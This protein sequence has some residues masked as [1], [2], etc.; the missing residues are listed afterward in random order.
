MSEVFHRFGGHA[1]RKA[2]RKDVLV[3]PLRLRLS[4]H[5]V[6][7]ETPFF[8]DGREASEATTHKTVDS[9]RNKGTAAVRA[10]AARWGRGGGHSRQ[11]RRTTLK[12]RLS[13]PREEAC[14][15]TGCKVCSRGEA[16][17]NER[18]YYF[19]GSVLNMPLT[20]RQGE[21]GR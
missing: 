1:L 15:E 3:P 18:R 2:G 20:P 16:Q 8:S 7:H 21:D 12:Q 6:D 13:R 17:N 19:G 4:A 10:R 9:W 14:L 11:A 5:R